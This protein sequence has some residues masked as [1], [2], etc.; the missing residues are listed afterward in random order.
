MRKTEAVSEVVGLKERYVNSLN[1]AGF[2]LK[3]VLLGQLATGRPAETF[4]M[5]ERAVLGVKTVKG[6]ETRRQRY[7]DIARKGG[8]MSGYSNRQLKMLGGKTGVAA[9]GKYINMV[10]DYAEDKYA[11]ERDSKDFRGVSR[12]GDLVDYKMKKA[13]EFEEVVVKEVVRI[14]IDLSG[15]MSEVLNDIVEEKREEM[16]AEVVVN[17]IT[18]ILGVDIG[19]D[20][21]PLTNKAQE[22]YARASKQA[23][24]G[25][26]ELEKEGVTEV[27]NKPVET[28][29]I[30][31]VEARIPGTE[32]NENKGPVGV[33]ESDEVVEDENSGPIGVVEELAEDEGQVEVRFEPSPKVDVEAITF[34]DKKEKETTGNVPPIILGGEGQKKPNEKKETE[35]DYKNSWMYKVGFWLGRQ[36]RRLLDFLGPKGREQRRLEREKREAKRNMDEGKEQQLKEKRDEREVRMSRKGSVDSMTAVQKAMGLARLNEVAKETLKMEEEERKGLEAFVGVKAA[37]LVGITEEN[38][39]VVVRKVTEIETVENTVKKK[40]FLSRVKSFFGIGG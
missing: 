4:S 34:E 30:R 31:E 20:G 22:A 6:L 36:T 40:E 19:Q 17:G 18:L 35:E 27:V 5:D 21:V 2:T 29:E 3:N 32:S 24:T 1:Q 15:E 11:E 23:E 12:G 7:F 26:G 13:R 14:P 39:G 8:D 33:G 38:F 10:D 37:D 25:A 28:G 16:G 9:I